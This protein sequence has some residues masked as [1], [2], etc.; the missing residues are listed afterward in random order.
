MNRLHVHVNV[1]DLDQSVRFYSSLFGAAPS[2]SKPDYAK[3]LLDDP[4]VNFA[5][6]SRGR[7]PSFSNGIAPSMSCTVSRK[8]RP[9][10]SPL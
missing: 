10:R 4:R 7:T 8:P 2:V 6:S 9:S 3:W 1:A 5:I